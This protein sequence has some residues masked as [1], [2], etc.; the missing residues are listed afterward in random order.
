MSYNI[1]RIQ[2]LLN[3]G[4]D[5]GFLPLRADEGLEKMVKNLRQYQMSNAVGV[6]NYAKKRN[7]A[8]AKMP[9]LKVASIPNPIPIPLYK[10]AIAKWSPWG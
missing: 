8:T 5:F 10:P 4:N 3:S 6:G 9:V 2:N 1:Q 7:I